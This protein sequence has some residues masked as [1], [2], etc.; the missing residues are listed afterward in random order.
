MRTLRPA[1]T[2]QPV[3]HIASAG[4]AVAVAVTAVQQIGRDLAK[5]I[6]CAS[7]PLVIELI[8]LEPAFAAVSRITQ[9]Q[10]QR[11]VLVV[12]AQIEGASRVLGLLQAFLTAPVIAGTHVQ[13]SHAGRHIADGVGSAVA[14][15]QNRGTNRR[16]AR[17]IGRKAGDGRDLRVNGR[18]CGRGG[19][20]AAQRHRAPVLAGQ[21]YIA[22]AKVGRGQRALIGLNSHLQTKQGLET[23]AQLLA[24]LEAK[25]RSVVAQL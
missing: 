4:G 19:I 11:A 20:E 6:A 12:D 17:I 15:I 10:L 24:A 25:A 13:A 2:G 16:Q 8:D 7:L 14:R 18:A 3:V 5:V 23:A 9:S 22:V 1:H 21:A